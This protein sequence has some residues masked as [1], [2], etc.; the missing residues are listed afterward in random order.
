MV[1]RNTSL[2]RKLGLKKNI[3]IERPLKSFPNGKM[4]P[5]VQNGQY[6]YSNQLTNLK[7]HYFAIFWEALQ[8]EVVVPQLHTFQMDLHPPTPV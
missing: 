8:F 3:I 2:E 4:L 6:T 7:P 5:F 1:L